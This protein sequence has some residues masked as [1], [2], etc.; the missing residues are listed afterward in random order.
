VREGEPPDFG[1][2]IQAKR[3]VRPTAEQTP[4]LSAS[5]AA[6]TVRA[7]AKTFDLLQVARHKKE[8]SIL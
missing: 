3:P 6:L 4:Q 8:R 7:T 5:S 1:L 2:L